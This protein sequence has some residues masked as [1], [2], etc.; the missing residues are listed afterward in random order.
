[1]AC[2]LNLN[3]VVTKKKKIAIYIEKSQILHL[4]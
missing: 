1:M 4:T 2:G 3:K